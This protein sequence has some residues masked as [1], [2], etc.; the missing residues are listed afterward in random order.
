MTAQ[1]IFL[2]RWLNCPDEK[3]R[4][5]DL[6][7]VMINE[8][9]A[10]F[11]Y[12]TRDY[13]QY[14]RAIS[15]QKSHNLWRQRMKIIGNQEEI[16]ESKDTTL[17]PNETLLNAVLTNNFNVLYSNTLSESEK[18]ELKNILSISYDDLIIKSNEL[19]ESIL[20]KVS[21]LMT[22]SN[23]VDLI[24]RLKAVRD[25]VSQMSPSR[26]NYYRL[27]ELKNGLN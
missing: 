8:E 27:T 12:E 26:Y 3:K 20:G 15:K 16:T 9:K 2:N 19:H 17:V 23:D 4:E 11:D 13:N 10:K 7:Q 21:T 18:E 1:V 22:E 25:E 24:S 5:H 6:M 14:Q